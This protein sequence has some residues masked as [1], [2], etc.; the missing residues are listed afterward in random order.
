MGKKAEPIAPAEA[1]EKVVKAQ[2]V[3]AKSAVKAEESQQRQ[4]K[5]TV[6]TEK[7]ALRQE[8][9]AER[10]TE[11]AADRTVYAAE[12]T[13]A[14]WMRSG[15]AALAAGVGARTLLTQHIPE[16]L[17][18]AT[19]VVLVGFAMF[20]FVAAVWREVDGRV[21]QHPDVRRLPGWVLVGFSAFLVLVSG[22][23]LAGLWL[24]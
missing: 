12:R 14:A 7:S 22:A 9:S 20:C 8:D 24:N 10:R 6:R 3:V 11:L 4:E 19:S 16:W 23:V 15:L 5:S 17:A 18:A 1:R 13:Y 21:A 2:R